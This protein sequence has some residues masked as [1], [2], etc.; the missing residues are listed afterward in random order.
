MKLVRFSTNQHA[1]YCGMD[2]PARSMDV[3]IVT[4]AGEVLL[5]RNMPAAPAPCSRP[6]A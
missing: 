1:L 5:H 6:G 4:H 3:W 2:L